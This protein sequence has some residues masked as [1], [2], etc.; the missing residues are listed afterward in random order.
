M[1]GQSDEVTRSG[2]MTCP[3]CRS[4]DAR[5][6]RRQYAADYILS[7]FGVYPWRC[8]DCHGRFHAR[9][10]SLGQSLRTHCPICG[11]QEVKRIA[12]DRVSAPL[13]FVWRFMRLPAYRCEPCRYKYFSI[14]P[15]RSEK[16]SQVG[17]LSSA[18]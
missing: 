7:L 1:L 5:R 8:N 4:K 16:E 18:G 6:S 10:M 17:Q 2:Q 14:R 9:M 15:R 3:I 11:N 12:S 13:S